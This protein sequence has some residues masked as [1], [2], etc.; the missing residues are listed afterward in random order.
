MK[1]VITNEESS[2][3]YIANLVDNFL[4]TINEQDLKIENKMVIVTV[5][6]VEKLN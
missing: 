1:K 6:I 2:I 5:E 4:D 3:N